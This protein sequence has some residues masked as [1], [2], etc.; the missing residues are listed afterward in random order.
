MSSFGETFSADKLEVRKHL[1]TKTSSTRVGTADATLPSPADYQRGDMWIIYGNQDDV[2][3]NGVF[4]HDG[5]QWFTC[6][7]MNAAASG[8]A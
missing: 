2:T 1:N 6:G 3:T 5:S 7:Q 8:G 4:I